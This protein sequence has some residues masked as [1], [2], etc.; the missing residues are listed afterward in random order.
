MK[1]L[2]LTVDDREDDRLLMLFMLES[3][4]YRSIA[5]A[6]GAAALQFTQCCQPVLILLDK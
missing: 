5:I 6:D 1:P 2:I 3:L 4:G